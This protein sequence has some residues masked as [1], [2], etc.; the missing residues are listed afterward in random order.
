MYSN[1]PELTRYF[2]V[3]LFPLSSQWI[4]EV[5]W[6]RTTPYSREPAQQACFPLH[7]SGSKRFGVVELTPTFPVGLPPLSSQWCQEVRC[8]RTATSSLEPALQASF[9]RQHSGSRGFGVVEPPRSHSNLPVGLLPHSSQ[10]LKEIR[11][12]RTAPN[13]SNLPCRPA[14]P[15]VTAIRGGSVYSNLPE[16]SL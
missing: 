10:W 7:D 5:R 8:G 14:S 11:W 2:P 4:E 16:P 6:G 15:F 9:P 12:G 1:L 3:G 13:H